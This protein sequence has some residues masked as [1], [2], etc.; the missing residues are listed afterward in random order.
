LIK[1]FTAEELQ[2]FYSYLQRMKANLS[3]FEG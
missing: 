1:G 2:T 3:P